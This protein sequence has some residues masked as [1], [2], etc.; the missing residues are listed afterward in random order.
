MV[1]YLRLYLLKKDIFKYL[2]QKKLSDLCCEN[3][4]FFILG[5]YTTTIQVLA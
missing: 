5:V 1:L 2:F 4:F 3:L